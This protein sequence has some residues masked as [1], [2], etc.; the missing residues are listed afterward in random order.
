M[1]KLHHTLVIITLA[2]A[3]LA[4]K[5]HLIQAS[6]PIKQFDGPESAASAPLPPPSGPETPRFQGPPDEGKGK[7]P[8]PQA[9]DPARVKVLIPAGETAPGR[10][11]ADYGAFRLVALDR[12]A[13]QRLSPQERA[14]WKILND[15]DK[16]LL[17]AGPL[18]TTRP[19]PDIPAP[20]RQSPGEGKRLHLVQFVGPVRDGWPE[21]LQ[22]LGLE[23][24][25]Y[26]PHNAYVIWGESAALKQ[27]DGLPEVQWH[28]PFHPYY[29]LH[30][31]LQGLNEGEVEVTFQVY[32]HSQSQQTM[33]AIRSAA[34]EIILT[35]SRVLTY[36]NITVRLPAERLIA[37]AQRADVVNIEPW[38]APV[39]LDEAQ[40]QIVAGN[41][42]VTGTGQL[43]PTGPG[44]L[45]WLNGLGFPTT[46]ISYPIVD[47]VDDGVGNGN[48]ADAGGDITLRELGSPANP[49]RVVFMNNC[50]VSP[51]P[52]GQDGHGHINT[53][54]VGGYAAGSGAPHTDANGFLLGQGVNPYGRLAATRIFNDSGQF[55]LN[56]CSGSYATLVETS[57]NSGAR[58]SSNSW[59]G[60]VNLGSYNSAS[61]V[62][63]ALT[64]DALGGTVGNQPM[65]FIFAAG[66][67]GPITDTLGWPG[68]AK[69]VITVGAGENV[70]D[71]G[72]ADG[73]G[74]INADNAEDMAAFSSRGPTDDGR[75]G[76]TVVA[77]GTHVQ[78][79]AST[80]PG[81]T[82][83]S[84]CGAF[85]NNGLPP[86]QDAYYPTG[87]ITYT[88]SSGTSH[89]TPA[90][91]GGASLLYYWLE[92]RY[93]LPNAQGGPDPAK[94]G[95]PPSPA[96]LKAFIANHARYMNGA[97][98]GGTLPSIDQGLG[99]I[100][101]GMAT[102][103]AQ[104]LL[105]DQNIV[106]DATGQVFTL[107]IEIVDNGRPFRATLAW[108]D[109]PG[110]TVGDAFVN[111]LDLEV[112]IGSNTYRG[113]VFNGANSTT[114]GGADPRNN[115]EA[116]FLPAGTS[117][118]AT[119]RVIAA[120]IAG[121]GVPGNS[122]VTDQDFALVV[123]NGR[124]PTG[125]FLS[126][127]AAAS[128]IEPGQF[129]TYTLSAFNNTGQNLTNIVITDALPANTQFVSVEGGG[130]FAGNVITWNG[131]SLAD[132]QTLTRAFT[133][134][135]GWLPDGAK[136][137][138]NDYAIRSAQGFTSTGSPLEVS[139]IWPNTDYGQLCTV[140]LVRETFETWPLTG[141]NIVDN[142]G[143][144]CSW[145]SDNASEGTPAD[146]CDASLSGLTDL[147]CTGG[148]GNFADADSDACGILSGT[149]M[150]TD[151]QTPLL[152]F[153]T[154]ISPQLEFKSDMRWFFAG[155]DERWD[156]D[157]SLDGG[158]SWS[159]NLLH[160]EDASRRGP[161][162]I[163]LDLSTAAGQ[164]DARVRFR[165]S[166]ANFDWWWQV[167]DVVVR[168]CDPTLQPLVSINKM[169]FTPSGL[170]QANE[171]LTYTLSVANY[172]TLTATVFITDA[173]PANTTF[174]R[175]EPEGVLLNNTI[176]WGFA[177]IPPNGRL[178]F[179]YAVTVGNVPTGTVISNND[180][181]ARTTLGE[182][183]TGPVVDVTV[184]QALFG[185]VYLPLIRKDI[186]TAPDLTSSLQL[187]PPRPEA[188]QP[189]TVTA[190]ISNIGNADATAFWVDFYVD[191]EPV[192]TGANQIWNDLGSKVSPPQGI[193]WFVPGLAAG[194]NTT[195][196]SHSYSTPHS[197]WS[198][199]FVAGTQDL[200]LYADSFNP[201]V[202][203]GGVPESNETNN[204]A[205]LLGINVAGLRVG[206]ISL[207]DPA[208]L[209]PR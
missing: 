107:T 182:N 103:N 83:A 146:T 185:P 12:A 32:D 113:N 28:G 93:T 74:K 106:L 33:D 174:A 100:D 41:L 191:P 22:Q 142:S 134:R 176:G 81:F 23:I 77:P 163:T 73:C 90:V 123:Y 10:I 87:Q 40:N 51:N 64:R 170:V 24:V 1:I 53:S 122:D 190:V 46:P 42:V 153:S 132:G 70:R 63:D 45:A 92:N 177:D 110:P 156:V 6:A 47:I 16:I 59:G 52:N 54:I 55:D 108:T 199:G 37:F 75:F 179:T 91:A 31:A 121:D 65:T 17:R 61:Q 150:D 114:G 57:Y 207:P 58:I 178:D 15:A 129:L 2:G 135:A 89:S 13:L 130:A 155:D 140:E 109:A 203:T 39:K 7:E 198:G 111:D 181:R 144:G 131:L 189:V 139:V 151:L 3:M 193:A 157:L 11:L 141:W 143:S 119:I 98:A 127:S 204:R 161:E 85:G 184:G 194:A 187:D 80:D 171:L 192:P 158:D 102:D 48:A 205:D 20:L 208:G 133:V 97:G 162:T 164:N 152:D 95:D 138:N 68:T 38:S 82:G 60:T 67:A 154:L 49:S 88:W 19:P 26:I 120:N 124:L 200:Y 43:A 84:V 69:N 195:L 128:T 173:I 118:L 147:N 66:N 115:L 166:N 159:S 186:L 18:D 197:V 117:G 201:G 76:L 137:S 196:T 125:L 36:R 209:P 25:Q 172:G 8:E 21:N 188:G 62:Y 148:S 206:E 50:T 4:V 126:K 72:I 27:L 71:N 5:P 112:I 35:E 94:N 14:G 167:D 56:N 79:T 165:Y 202:E 175:A 9:T 160:H 44:Y 29:A 101:L 34:L 96:L 104:R 86:P 183:A 30:P 169:P 99:L 145:Y 136:L 105:R 168:A 116:V 180:Y 78:G 149:T